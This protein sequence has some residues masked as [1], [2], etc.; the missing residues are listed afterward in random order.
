MSGM[1]FMTQSSLLS[2]SFASPAESANTSEYVASPTFVMMGA[3]LDEPERK[4]GLARKLVNW[5]GADVCEQARRRSASEPEGGEGAGETERVVG[6][7]SASATATAT[8]EGQEDEGGE[9]GTTGRLVEREARVGRGGDESV[10]E[11]AGVL[12]REREDR[13]EMDDDEGTAERRE[14]GLRVTGGEEGG[15]EGETDRPLSLRPARRR[16]LAI[17]SS[18]EDDDLNVDDDLDEADGLSLLSLMPTFS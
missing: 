14:V 5:R 18:D 7:A 10:T 8:G 1:T 2:P 9:S 16:G 12:E 4:C 13:D 11:S 6:R 3:A 15:G 17:T